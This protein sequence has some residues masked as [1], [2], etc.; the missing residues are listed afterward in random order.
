ML[1]LIQRLRDDGFEA[2]LLTDQTNWV[3]EVNEKTP[4][5][6]R[7]D[8][9]FN[10]YRLGK[11]KRD[12][13]IFDEVLSALQVDPDRIIFVDDKDENIRLAERSG[14]R[15][16][17]Y[18]DKNSFLKELYSHLPELEGKVIC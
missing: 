14:I 7:F 13:S 8:R 1:E 5:Y 6:D 2:V 9:V 10:S 4:F 11:C 15:G 17:L 18:V 3:E 12:G 16:I